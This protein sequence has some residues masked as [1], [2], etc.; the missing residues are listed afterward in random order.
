MIRLFIVDDHAVL[1]HGLRRLF[2]Q[3]PNLTVVGEAANGQQLLEQ[4]PSTPVDLVLLDL[5]MPVLD[6][7]ATAKRLRADYPA[8]RILML[9]MVE[10]PLRIQQALTAGAQ[11]YLLKNAAKEEV[12]AAVQLVL[13]GHPFLSSEVGL[14][15]LRLVVDSPAPVAAPTLRKPPVLSQRE[16]EILHLVAEGLTTSQIADQL[17]ASKR[18]IETHRQNM[19]E[20]TG[21]NNTAMLISY[22]ITHQLITTLGSAKP[23]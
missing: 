17:F 4:L 7:L 16:R 22:A 1:R 6:G 3:E 13:A 14:N 12:L 20:K 21:C 15:L 10:E 18:T 8:L 2:E 11:G 23:E 9:S 19:L 5:N